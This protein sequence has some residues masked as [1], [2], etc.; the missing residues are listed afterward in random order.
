MGSTRN[1]FDRPTR[2]ISSRK[3]WMLRRSYAWLV[4]T[5]GY[6]TQNR[7]C[8][9]D[10][11]DRL[12]PKAEQMCARSLEGALKRTGNVV[13]LHDSG[14]NREPTLEALPQIIDELHAK[15]SRF[16]TVHELLDLPRAAVMPQSA[17]EPKWFI[18]SNHAGFLLYSLFNS[19]VILLFYLAILSRAS[20]WYLEIIVGYLFFCSATYG[21]RKASPGVHVDAVLFFGHR[22]AY[23]EERVIC[24]SINAL[25]ASSFAGLDNR[26]R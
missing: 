12:R 24:A 6:I 4:T 3:P 17:R 23:N 13:L 22:P 19:I 1:S 11:K 21:S 25:L 5:T 7:V 14:G 18:T 10:P 20:A 16:V 8:E 26:R 9:S 15:G 2:E